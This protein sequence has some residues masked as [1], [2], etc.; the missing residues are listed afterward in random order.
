[1]EK[2]NCILQNYH[3]FRKCRKTNENFKSNFFEKKIFLENLEK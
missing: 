3:C 1:M 2:N